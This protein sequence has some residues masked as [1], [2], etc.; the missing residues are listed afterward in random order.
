MMKTKVYTQRAVNRLV[1]T[2]I[3]VF[4]LF[5]NATLCLLLP[6]YVTHYTLL[7]PIY[8][9]LLA[10][11]LLWASS[12]LGAGHVGAVRALYLMMMLSAAQLLVSTGIVVLYVF[13]VGVQQKAFVGIFG[14]HYLWFLGWKMFVL[15]Q[16]EQQNRLRQPENKVKKDEDETDQP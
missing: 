6:E 11:S 13:L 16:M 2:A 15:R 8:Y 1:V 9:L 5:V 10:I 14:L 3:V 4:G 7:V 12:R